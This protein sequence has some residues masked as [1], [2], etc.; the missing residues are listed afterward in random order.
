MSAEEIIGHTVREI[1]GEDQYRAA[2]PYIKR[3][4]AGEEVAYDAERRVGN[5]E[6]RHYLS[7]LIPHFGENRE[8]LGYYVLF[9]DIT[10][11]KLAEQATREGKEAAELAQTRS[12]ELAAAMSKRAE[13]EAA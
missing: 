4:L 13:K 12:A 9:T 1:R 8:V 5:G 3:V 2:L 11:Q 10:A 7:H 6:L